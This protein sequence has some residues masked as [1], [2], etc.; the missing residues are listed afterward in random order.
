[1]AAKCE[2]RGNLRGN[3]LHA[4][5]REIDGAGKQRVLEFLDED[6][7]AADSAPIGVVDLRDGGGLQAIARGA[8]ADDFRFDAVKLRERSAM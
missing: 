7:F 6:A 5:D 1:M 8:D 3:V 4:V 2:A